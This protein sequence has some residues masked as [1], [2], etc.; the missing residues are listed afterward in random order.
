MTQQ[1]YTRHGYVRQYPGPEGIGIAPVTDLK[2]GRGEEV[3][4]RVEVP[5]YGG[6]PLSAVVAA[7]GLSEVEG[8]ERPVDADLR[9]GVPGYGGRVVGVRVSPRDGEDTPG[10][11][12]PVRMKVPG[13]G[14]ARFGLS[15]WGRK[16]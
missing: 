11:A 5:G 6:A 12:R 15:F 4:L 16:R 3:S 9:I 14:G 10:E 13:Y 7:G 1:E 8:G 2:P